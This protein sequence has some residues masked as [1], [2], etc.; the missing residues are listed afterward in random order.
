MFQ[1]QLAL[2]DDMVV[3]IE[4]GTF[5]PIQPG[6][7]EAKRSQTQKE[8]RKANVNDGEVQHC[9]HLHVI[10]P[11]ISVLLVRFLPFFLFLLPIPFFCHF[12]RN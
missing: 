2:D 11:V 3:D 5:D 7:E 12:S 4:Y 6:E 9:V 10:T 8:K 1:T